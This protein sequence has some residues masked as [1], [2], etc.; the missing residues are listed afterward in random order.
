MRCLRHADVRH[1]M[2][3]KHWNNFGVDVYIKLTS[4]GE[5]L[6]LD[7]LIGNHD[8]INDVLA[9]ENMDSFTA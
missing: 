6:V 1:K 2:W 4:I 8:I 7:I 3:L 9:R 5:A